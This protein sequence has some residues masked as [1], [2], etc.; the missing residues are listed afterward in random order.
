MKMKLLAAAVAATACGTQAFAAQVY[1]N[2]G[3]TLSIGGHVS[4]GVGEYDGGVNYDGS[5][6]VQVN[7]VSPRINVAGSQDLGNGVVVDAKGE[8]SLNYLEGGDNSFAT[9]LGYIGATHDDYG[10]LVVG[11]QWSPYYDVG[12]IAD[13]P[14][15]FANNFL[16]DDQYDLGTARAERMVSYRNA[17]AIGDVGEL[18]MGLG[19]QGEH[20]MYDARIQAG[21]TFSFSAFS[22]GYAYSGGDVGVGSQENAESSIFSAKYGSYGSG[23]YV[24]LVYAMNDYMN[25]GF[26]GGKVKDSDAYEA[27]VAYGLGNGLNLSINYE[28]VEDNDDSDTVF[29][30]TALQAEYNF[31][32]KLV[33]FAGYQFD[34]GNDYNSDENDEWIIGARY[35]L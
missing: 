18:A 33:G 30:Q 17:F 22:I 3:T 24:A 15:A 34:L 4:V 8:W 12:G 9:R 6:E 29:S 21:L 23:L 11:T 1:N 26:A 7:Q 5:D 28:A 2:E 27:L 20:D 35:Y 31:T 32:P 16:Y 13:L 10:R 19:W 14:I 25:D